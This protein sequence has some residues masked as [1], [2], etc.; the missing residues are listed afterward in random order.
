MSR[1]ITIE[2]IE[3]E[4]KKQKQIKSPGPDGFIG[5]FYQIFNVEL[6]PIFLKTILRKWTG[7][8]ASELIVW[9]HHALD[10]KTRKKEN[11]RPVLLLEPPLLCPDFGWLCLHFHLSEVLFA[12][13]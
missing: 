9:E 6:M 13:F 5:E 3:S 12:F 11:Y 2:E 8:D 4:I 10:T 1:T 7:G